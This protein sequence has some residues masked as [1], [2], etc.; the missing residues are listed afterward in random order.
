MKNQI[1]II[2]L[3]LDGTL[4]NDNKEISKRNV[5]SIIKFQKEGGFVV[6]TSSRK[7]RDIESYARQ[8]ELY[9]S[10]RGFVISGAGLYLHNLKTGEVE[11]TETFNKKSIK[12]VAGSLLGEFADLACILVASDYDYIIYREYSLFHCIR[13]IFFRLTCKNVRIIPL[14]AIDKIND[15]IEKIMIYTIDSERIN[16]SL[17]NIQQIYARTIDKNRTEILFHT[18]SKSNALQKLIEKLS[19]DN[20]S[21]LVFGDDEND[22]DCFETFQN[23][24]AMGNAIESIK[25]KSKYITKSNNDDGISFFMENHIIH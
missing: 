18:V 8:L 16:Q 10:G 9:G 23:T 17:E 4:L 7:Y 14:S 20:K 12:N 3:D 24:V 22:L 19:I 21:V 11:K 25:S 1:K 13:N 2:S 5:D 6:L 15:P